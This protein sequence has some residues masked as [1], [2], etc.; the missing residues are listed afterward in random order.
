MRVPYLSNPPTGFTEAEEEIVQRIA[1]R[2]GEYGLLPLD[3]VLLHAPEIANGWDVL[4]SAIRDK[5]SLPDHLREIAIV[6]T[7]VLNKAWYEWGWH[8]P[9]LQDTEPFRQSPNKMHTVADPNPL[10]PGELD[11]VEWT[12]LKFADEIT[13]N[14]NPTDN[15]FEKL[16]SVCGFSNREIV[17]LTATVSGYNFASRECEHR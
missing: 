15:T 11:E 16:R 1:A 12:V 4:F 5:S 13:K 6:R 14:I 2:R 8:A 3:L 10:D 7:A 17:E 9:L